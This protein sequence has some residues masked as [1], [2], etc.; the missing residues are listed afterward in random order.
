ME[1]NFF[2]FLTKEENFQICMERMLYGANVARPE[3]RSIG[4]VKKGDIAFVW[5][6]N[7]KDLYGIFEVEDRIYYDESDIGWDGD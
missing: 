7:N 2:I 3:Q 4:N 6:P 1:R 5:V